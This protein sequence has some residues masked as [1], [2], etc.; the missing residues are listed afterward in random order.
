MFF[1]LAL[2]TAVTASADYTD[3]IT[4]ADLKS[5]NPDAAVATNANYNL[6]DKDLGEVEGNYFNNEMLT[7]EGLSE[8]KYSFSRAILATDFIAFSYHVYDNGYIANT[9]EPGEYL[10]SL[11]INA[12]WLDAYNLY[13]SNE[14]PVT[15][16][17]VTA[18][19]NEWTIDEL[20]G[21]K[22]IYN[23]ITNDNKTYT[24]EEPYKYFMITPNQ[25]FLQGIT[26][27]WTETA[28]VPTVKDPVIEMYGD[29]QPG[30]S[31]W[32]QNP[33]GADM[34]VEVYVNDTLEN[35]YTTTDRNYEVIMPGK[36]DDVVRVAAIAKKE[37]WNDSQLVEKQ[38]TL[39]APMC[40]TPEIQGER[41]VY[42]V[43]AGQTFTVI[44]TNPENALVTYHYEIANFDDESR[45]FTS[46]EKTVAAPFEF[47][48]PETVLP[49]DRFFLNVVANAEGYRTSYAE[50]IISA[51]VRSLQLTAPE[52]TPNG[53]IVEKGSNVTLQIPGGYGK[54]CYT[55]NGGDVVDTQSSWVQVTIEE[56]SEITAWTTDVEPFIESEKVT[57]KF[58]LEKIGPDMTEIL[59][60]D[61]TDNFSNQTMAVY[62]HTY[63]NGMTYQY[64][65]GFWDNLWGTPTNMFLFDAVNEN[66]AY[67]KNVEAP[68]DGMNIISVK[69]NAPNEW[70][71][72]YLY[73]SD[74]PFEI[75]Y[76]MQNSDFAQEGLGRVAF[77]SNN[78]PFNQWY[79]LEGVGA[80]YIAVC[81]AGFAYST[82]YVTRVVV[83]YNGSVGV[84]A[85]EAEKV[86]GEAYYTLDGVKVDSDNLAKGLY[87]RVADGKASKILVK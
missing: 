11:T 29:A 86:A 41:G 18:L 40:A 72:L 76:E 45:N 28:P 48:V 8:A 70:A 43:Y 15:V 32:I 65:G 51:E 85:L 87:I 13:V 25:N 2:M 37:G 83:K 50:N 62:D 14:R 54:I 9:T 3:V 69:I 36:A 56:D 81:T 82:R 6:V 78:N 46:E 68:A 73:Y 30:A 74:E 31:I 1:G 16:E 47:T 26:V 38:W 71:G 39:V 44:C 4:V 49:G 35:T 42:S 53:G 17:D 63:A 79:D 21:V 60:E 5:E 80:K 23:A 57:V 55:I 77:G 59:P 7:Y 84:N 52:I 75:T 33:S 27:E 10:K 19:R 24:F 61:F 58:E 22:K 12:G 20:N 34:T 67:L 66:N 64:N